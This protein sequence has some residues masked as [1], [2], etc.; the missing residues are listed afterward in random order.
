MDGQASQQV[1]KDF[2]TLLEY[3]G[4]TRSQWAAA[5]ISGRRKAHEHLAEAF[6]SYIMEG[7]APNEQ[8]RNAF[9]RFADWLKAVYKAIRRKQQ[10]IEEYVEKAMDVYTD[11]HTSTNQNTDAESLVK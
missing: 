1:E 9:R 3:A 2:D 7:K 6:E 11:I 5:D 8:L 10:L 4:M